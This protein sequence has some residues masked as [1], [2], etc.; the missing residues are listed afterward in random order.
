MILTD[1]PW[2]F[3]LLCLLAG[4]VYA[5]VLYFVGRN[6]FGRGLRWVLTV[7]R[8]LT[9]SVIAFLLMSP[10]SRQT[11][12]ERQKPHLV[13]AQDVSTSVTKSADSTFTL[14][15]LV[16]DLEEHFRISHIS[17]G[18]AGE[19]NLGAVLDRWRGDDVAAL[20]IAS[21][22]IH[23]RGT[24][25]TSAAERLAFPVHCIALGDTTPQRDALPYELH[26]NRIAMMGGTFPVEFVVKASLLAGKSTQV[27]IRD[28]DGRQLFQQRVVY[29]NDHFSTTLSIQLPADKAGLQRYTLYL[30]PV[31]DECIVDNNILTFYVD[32]L[33]T[34][35]HVVIFANAPH[36]DL[37]ALKRSIESNPNYEAEVVL[38]DEVEAHKWKMPD[39]VS[40]AILH[41]LPSQRHPSV[42]YADPLPT[43]FIIGT[44]T[45]LPRFNALHTGLEIIAR[46]ISTNE[47]TALRRNEFTLFHI[48]ESDFD[49][50]EALPPLSA[51]FGEALLK[52]DVQP[53]LTARLG[54]F[55]TR[56]P[57]VAASA[58]NERR[59][60]FIWGEGLWRWRL[61]DWQA[62]ESFDHVDRLVSQL[63]AFTAMQTSHKR[64]QI[65]TARS[66][67]AG[68]PIELH[69]I[70]YDETY[71]PTNRPEVQFTLE[72]DSIKADYT[73]RR[74]AGGYSLTLPPLGEGL[75]RFHATADG[76]T[77]EGSFAVEA[78]NLER[79]RLNAD[80]NLL[81]T[82]ASLTGGQLYHPD[83]L[84]SLKKEL[85]TIK[86]IIYTHSR[87]AE[88]LRLPLVLALILLLLATEWVLRKIHGEL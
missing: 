66:Y 19:T 61:A 4:G 28:N 16:P 7:L 34:R 57:L 60:T 56:Q 37:A 44:R 81:A 63:V 88:F 10:M 47:V 79:Q 84:S 38:A 18:T 72:G 76:Q 13:L 58:Q 51:P 22:G 77:A 65:E 64:L 39:D 43:L 78:L 8:F 26:C 46:T 25:P 82:I 24:S 6:S 1:Y 85:S 9:V 11:V 14:Q 69:A 45:D 30:A 50:L 55:D 23:N 3:T 41:N 31:E 17:F 53:L 20:V 2:Y 80:H 49:V 21:D 42:A 75:Y 83:Q 40:L 86:P 62:H 12:T 67:V 70:L 73:F 52:P 35:R 29:D 68:E 32:V 87:Y 54:N 27:T 48:D 33:N 71:E 5:A 74:N 36:P 59:H 15:D